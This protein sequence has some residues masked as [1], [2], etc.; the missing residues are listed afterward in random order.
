MDLISR[1]QT[2]MP[3]LDTGQQ[4]TALFLDEVAV[5]QWRLTLHYEDGEDRII[6]LEADGPA[7]AL[8]FWLQRKSG[9]E[10]YDVPETEAEYYA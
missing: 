4:V 3:D 1:L 5:D 6:A 7:E 8:L 9:V 10:S 2:A